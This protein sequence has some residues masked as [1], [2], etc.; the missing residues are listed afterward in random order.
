[1][2]QNFQTDTVE[3]CELSR[4]RLKTLTRDQY[5]MSVWY[6]GLNAEPIPDLLKANWSSKVLAIDYDS[7]FEACLTISP[8]NVD[9][10]FDP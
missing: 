7:V 8:I 3:A 6:I 4:A 9:L 10:V 1:M 2:S 5:G